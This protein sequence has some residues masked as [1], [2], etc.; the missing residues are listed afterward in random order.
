MSLNTIK[1]THTVNITVEGDF[2]FWSALKEEEENDN[3]CN[4]D[5]SCLLTQEALGLN[6]ITLPCGHKYNYIPICKEIASMKNT[7]HHYYNH[8]IKLMRGQTYCPY[9]RQVF[10]KLL[11]KI[12]SID[13][14]PEKYVCS[15]TNYIDHRSC[16]H[17]FQS[18]KRKGQCCGKKN[19]FDS[20]YG[21]FCSHHT[22]KHKAVKTA[23]TTTKKSSKSIELN[24]EG[25]K[26]WNKYKVVDLKNILRK[27]NLPLSGA[28]ALL[29]T[30]I[31]KANIII[32]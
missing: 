8:G 20:Q 22:C 1:N 18:G 15:S 14:T 11:P 13:F 4:H 12:P 19:A 32:E 6:Y 23:K 24:D 21:T 16:K 5:D 10:N 7:K 9:C 2:D 3:K 27:N 29:I 17:V 31:M 25:K 26:L 30:R 28:K